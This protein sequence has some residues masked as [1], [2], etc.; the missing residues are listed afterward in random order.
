MRKCE[1]DINQIASE[2]AAQN[3]R[4]Q[5]WIETDTPHSVAS[6]IVQESE[7]LVEAIEHFD[8]LQDAEFE[9]VSEIGDILYLTLRLCSQLGIDPAEAVRMKIHRNSVKYPDH[10]QS[11][12][13]SYEQARDMSKSLWE[14]LG[15]DHAFFLWYALQYPIDDDSSDS[16]I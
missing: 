11:N 16:S 8:V 1:K 5:T 4:R 12:G 9:V 15:G 6:H 7:E 3:E 13:W 2:I 14:A 10:F